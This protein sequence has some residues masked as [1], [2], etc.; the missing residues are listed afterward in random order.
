MKSK[1]KESWRGLKDLGSRLRRRVR[2]SIAT[3]LSINLV[4]IITLTGLLFTI[5]GVETI[6]SLTVAEAEDRVRNDLNTARLIYQEKL[7]QVSQATEFT[8]GRTFIENI[9]LS[10]KLLIGLQ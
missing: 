6:S 8:A 3:R 4:I 2:S 10:Y 5:V 7:N 9:L 1:L